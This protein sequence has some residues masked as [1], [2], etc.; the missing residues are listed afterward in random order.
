MKKLK[1]FLYIFK[2]SISS[3]SYYKDILET[4]FSFSIKYLAALSLVATMIVTASIYAKELPNINTFVDTQITAVSNGYPDNLEITVKDKDWSIN[5]AEPYAIKT[6]ETLK[7]EDNTLPEN[8]IIFNRNGTINDFDTANALVLVNSTNLIVK[9]TEGFEVQP[10]NEALKDM[11]EGTL[12][13]EGFTKLI[14][15]FSKI[16]KYIAPFFLVMTF[17]FI[18][19][20]FFVFRMIYLLFVAMSLWIVNMFIK[21]DVEFKHLYRIGLHSMTVPLVIEVLLKVAGISFM[22]IPWFFLLNIILGTLVMAKA[23]KIDD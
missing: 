2:R 9:T 16:T 7:T 22:A 14:T 23:M 18:F 11:P 1:A 13:K 6:P 17:V 21:P 12:N 5:Q 8:L 10:L 20:Y 4:D 19:T 3:F 15:E